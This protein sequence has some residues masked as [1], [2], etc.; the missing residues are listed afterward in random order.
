MRSVIFG[1]GLITVLGLISCQK[2]LDGTE[3]PGQTQERFLTKVVYTELDATFVDSFEYDAQGRCTRLV[4]LTYF[5][6]MGFDPEPSFY[7]FYYNGADTLPF[8]ITDTSQGRE[9]IWLI[10]YDSQKRKIADSILYTVSGGKSVSYYTYSPNAITATSTYSQAGMPGNPVQHIYNYDGSN[11]TKYSNSGSGGAGSFEL[12]MTYDNRINPIS[13]LNIANAVLFGTVGTLGDFEGLN[14]N[15]YLSVTFA[16]PTIP[17][18]TTNYQYVYD[19]EGYPLSATYIDQ[20]NP[21]Q[22]GSVKYEYKK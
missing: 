8:K 16:S 2:E 5:S 19:A 9:M 10:Q 22:A 13:R 7:D 4:I 1:L 14:R 11:C 20:S 21:S 3:D 6:G 17:G 12:T 18:G 15:N